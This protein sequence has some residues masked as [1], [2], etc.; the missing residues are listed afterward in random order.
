MKPTTTADLVDA[1]ADA[2]RSGARLELRGGGSKA[3]IGAARDATLLDMTGFAGVIDYDPAELVLTVGAGTPLAEI[4]ALV[5][6]ERQMLAFEPYDHGPIFGRPP[7]SATIGG[8]IA[9]GGAGSRR[10]SHGSARDHLLG[11]EGVSGRG[12][13]FVAGAKVV[14]NVT[15]YDLPKLATGSWGRLLA[16]TQVTVKV[17]P[18]PRV[19]ATL[20]IEGLSPRAAHAAMA[21][22]MGAP[23]EIAAAAHVPGKDMRVTALRIDGFEPS[24]VARSASLSSLLADFGYVRALP[25]DEA[26]AFWRDI[27]TVAPL[28]TDGPLWRVNVPP[29]GGCA[30]VEALEPMGARWLFDWAG[31][32]VWLTCN[33]DPALIRS[34]A[35]G[36]GGHAIL[37]RA[38]ADLRT[39]IP[40]LHPAQPVVATLERRI[41]R[42]FDPASVFETGRFLDHS[43]AD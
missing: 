9:A 6:A 20:V 4:E 31:G 41:R 25:A 36:A 29:S 19:Q 1:I 23:L 32:L 35:E 27:A 43:D 40:A 30:V 14:K 38:P 18:R 21:R 11:F 39:R 24:V 10:L 22:A 26:N 3:A 15:G 2:A 28:P 16:L 17:L 5:A 33:A 8:V 13:A 42:A 7:G 34:V 12:E 37:I